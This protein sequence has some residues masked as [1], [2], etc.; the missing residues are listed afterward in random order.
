VNPRVETILRGEYPEIFFFIDREECGLSYSPKVREFSLLVRPDGEAGQMLHFCP[1]SGK[2]FPDS[3]RDRF[4][5]EL[6]AMGLTDGL[7]DV[8][9]APAE[10]QSEAWWIGRGL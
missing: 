3:L 2:P 5:D 10:F 4:F 9:R 1:F 7:A 8:E 6:D